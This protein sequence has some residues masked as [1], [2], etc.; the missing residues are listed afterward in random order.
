MTGTTSILVYIIVVSIVLIAILVTRPGI[1]A[2]KG[3][4]ILAFVAFLIFPLLSGGMGVSQHLEHSKSTKFCTS[5][6][7]M[8]DYG[9]SLRIDDRS[10]I[11]A[12]HYQN[13]LV[14]RENACYTCHT[15]YAMY[16][17]FRSKIRGLKHVYAQYLS[18]PAQPIKLYTP[19][20][21]RECLHCHLGSR[22]F[23]EGATHNMEPETLPKVKANELGCTSTGCHEMVHNVSG[24]KDVTFWNPDAKAKEEVKP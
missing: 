16:G 2:T 5:C 23:E 10:Y 21:N 1:T 18:T 9:L 17:D 12:V 19:Y 24:L 3:G 13:N 22:S 7:V 15:D 6:H 8:E 4:K 20:N 14:P 11:P